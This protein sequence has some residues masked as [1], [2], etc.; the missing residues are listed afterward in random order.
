[1][2]SDTIKILSRCIRRKVEA[3]TEPFVRSGGGDIV[4]LIDE[5]TDNYHHHLYHNPAFGWHVV[6]CLSDSNGDFPIF[7]LGKLTWL[8][9]ALLWKTHPELYGDH[10]SVVPVIDAWN[11]KS[12]EAN[13]ATRAVLNA[14]LIAEDATIEAVAAALNL[15]VNTVEAYEVL[16]FNVIGR[17][18]NPMYLRN[19]A[20]PETRLVETLEHYLEETD[21][22]T[23]LLRI[24][25]NQG[26]QQVLLAAGLL[27]NPAAGMTE[28]EA[29]VQFK[30]E[31][32]A[33]SIKLV[34]AGFLNYEKKHPAIKRAM[35][36]IKASKTSRQAPG[37]TKDEAGNEPGLAEV[38][39]AQLAR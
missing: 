34:A 5:Y 20:Y 4:E 30:D 16:F 2:T 37:G 1:M 22:D 39:A 14:A 13:R 36:F 27:D 24:G 17:K 11:I 35:E 15:P 21:P 33:T 31:M 25:Y 23:L 9:R 12:G 29:A 26:L 10:P 3:Q 32:L 7:P 8:F 38:L 6:E 28:A 19:I 18:E